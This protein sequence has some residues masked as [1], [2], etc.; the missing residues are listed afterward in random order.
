MISP[1]RIFHV[2]LIRNFKHDDWTMNTN[3]ACSEGATK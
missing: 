3:E 1:Q 2:F